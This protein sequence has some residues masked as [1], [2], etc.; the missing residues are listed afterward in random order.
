MKE[1]KASKET[2]R[3]NCSSAWNEKTDGWS[4]LMSRTDKINISVG[5]T[6]QLFFIY[7]KQSTAIF[8]VK[9]LLTLTENFCLVFGLMLSGRVYPLIWTSLLFLSLLSLLFPLS[10]DSEKTVSFCLSSQCLSFSVCPSLF[11]LFSSI[12]SISVSCQTVLYFVSPFCLFL[13]AIIFFFFTLYFYIYHFIVCLFFCIK[14]LAVCVCFCLFLFSVFCFNS[15]RELSL[16]INVSMFAELSRA[17]MVRIKQEAI[18]FANKKKTLWINFSLIKSS[19][20]YE[21]NNLIL[22]VFYL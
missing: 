13:F 11:S 10:H 18:S 1:P 21:V 2:V 22:I 16:F 4:Y 20:K 7:E 9:K 19:W 8:L 3:K 17:E 5:F 6:S 15:A 12:F 14:N